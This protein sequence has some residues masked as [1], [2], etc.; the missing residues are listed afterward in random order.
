MKSMIVLL[1][2]FCLIA[3]VTRLPDA[4]EN[5]ASS[6]VKQEKFVQYPGV[7]Q[8]LYYPA[9]FYSYNAKQA[10]DRSARAWWNQ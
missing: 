7:K 5:M 1:T 10:Q 3:C 9:G 4:K 8:K 2:L 6:H